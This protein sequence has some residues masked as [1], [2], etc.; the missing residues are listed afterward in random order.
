MRILD[1][2]TPHRYNGGMS[3]DVDRLVR[4]TLV[5][6]ESMWDEITQ[7]RA[8]ERIESEMETLRRLLSI[9]LKETSRG[10]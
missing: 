4:K 9:A 3:T 7:Y 2:I 10:Q 5:L 8:K 6:R 1:T